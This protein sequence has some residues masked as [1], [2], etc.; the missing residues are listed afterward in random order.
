MSNVNKN[1]LPSFDSLISVR[2]AP[3]DRFTVLH[4][5]RSTT[6]LNVE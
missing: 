3:N 6:S 4:L 2:L 5:F 1:P